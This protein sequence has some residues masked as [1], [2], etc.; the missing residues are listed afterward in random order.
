LGVVIVNAASH[1]QENI[2]SK[3]QLVKMDSNLAG[4]IT[5]IKKMP[6]EVEVGSLWDDIE[7]SPDVEYVMMNRGNVEWI[8]AKEKVVDV[9]KDAFIVIENYPLLQKDIGPS[10]ADALSG[11]YRIMYGGVRLEDLTGNGSG[12]DTV[13]GAAPE[14]SAPGVAMDGVVN[15]TGK[16]KETRFFVAILPASNDVKRLA[17]RLEPG[18]RVSVSGVLLKSADKCEIAK[19]NLPEELRG[20]KILYVTYMEIARQKKQRKDVPLPEIPE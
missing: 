11:F 7:I 15:V 16:K 20:M 19:W 5:M 8:F 9:D 4:K 6:F 17:K 2:I 14:E 3:R 1:S 18:D 10:P 13:I 12:E